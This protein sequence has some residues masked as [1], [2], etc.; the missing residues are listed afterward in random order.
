MLVLLPAA[1]LQTIALTVHLEDVDMVGEPV[2]ERTG[3][4]FGTQHGA[5]PQRLTV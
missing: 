5:L 2:E 4:A 3:K 1:R